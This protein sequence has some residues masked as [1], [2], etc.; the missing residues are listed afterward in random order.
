MRFIVYELSRRDTPP[1]LN[2]KTL[3]KERMMAKGNN[4]QRNDKKKKKVK[5]DKTKPSDQ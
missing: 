2:L 4:A 3:T 5:K 1:A